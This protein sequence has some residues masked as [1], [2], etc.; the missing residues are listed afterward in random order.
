MKLIIF[1][2][3]F[4]CNKKRNITHNDCGAHRRLAVDC[5]EGHT[6]NELLFRGCN[7]LLREDVRAELLNKCGLS[8]QHSWSGSEPKEAR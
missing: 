5:S 7:I 3:I 2:L 4:S 6:R 1:L 8:Y